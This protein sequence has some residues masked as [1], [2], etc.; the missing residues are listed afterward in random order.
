MSILEKII[1]VFAPH[2]CLGCGVEN[3]LLLCAQCRRG[4]PR[5]PSRC[6]HCRA[7]TDA[8]AVCGQCAGHTPL[9]QVIAYTHH[10]GLAKELLHRM[11]Y[12][13][14]Q[15]GLHEA[16]AMMAALTGHLPE[17]AVLVH[18][19]T[20]TSRVRA[21]GYD[22]ARV[23]A[24][25]LARKSGLRHETFLSRAGQARQ[26]GSNRSERLRQLDGAFRPVRTRLVRG[27]HIV[28]V[29]DVLTTGASLETAARVLRRAGAARVSAIVFAQA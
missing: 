20:A 10:Q 2:T 24:R 29:D 22:H 14:A 5:V 23:L 16:A 27:Q 19:P 9:R 4:L 18:I 13:R 15:A 26:V 28:L 12:E 1:S 21:R 7:V 6:Y 3:D 17:G 8:Y 25:S 11:K